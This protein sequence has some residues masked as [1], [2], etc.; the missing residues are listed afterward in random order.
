MSKL[1]YIFLYIIHKSFRSICDKDQINAGKEKKEKNIL[2]MCS[3]YDNNIPLK[4]NLET[5]KL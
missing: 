5:K 2:K 1:V 4:K 3:C